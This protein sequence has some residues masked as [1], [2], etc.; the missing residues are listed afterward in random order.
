[1]F[2]KLFCIEL[3]DRLEK[4]IEWASKG[5]QDLHSE[6]S[7]MYMKFCTEWLNLIE[8]EIKNPQ[9]LNPAGNSSI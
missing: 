5:K 6:Q 4:A 8:Q 2:Q 9:V 1:M 7:I 3:R